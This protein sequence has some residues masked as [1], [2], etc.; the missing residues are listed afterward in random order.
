MLHLPRTSLVTICSRGQRPHRAN[1]NAHTAFFTFKMIF[2]VGSDDRAYSPVLHAKRPDVHSFATHAHTAIAQN[3]P[4]P[5]EVDNRRPLLL[6]AMLFR[7]HVLRFSGAVRERHI[8]QL[9]F[10]ASITYRT[11]QRMISQQE[12][13]HALASLMNLWAIS[14]Y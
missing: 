7:L 5:I 8:L 1:I 12:F 10:A 3:A 4:R 6:V 2:F 14:R 9:A 13:D 11:I